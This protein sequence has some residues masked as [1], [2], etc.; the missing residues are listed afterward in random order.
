MQR[1]CPYCA[2]SI[3][4]RAKV[5]RFC[6]AKVDPIFVEN[7]QANRQ[8]CKIMDWHSNGCNADDISKKMNLAG[9]LTLDSNSSWTAERIQTIL[10]SFSGNKPQASTVSRKAPIHISASGSFRTEQCKCACLK[11]NSSQDELVTFIEGKCNHVLHAI[12][13]IFT[14][15]WGI[16]WLII[17]IGSQNETKRNRRISIAERKC[18]DCGSGLVPINE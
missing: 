14:F 6:S 16:G 15:I 8:I 5:C 3:Q 18:N 7:V 11:C 17:F 4:R 9:D 2:E 12:I 13:T 10:N 1:E